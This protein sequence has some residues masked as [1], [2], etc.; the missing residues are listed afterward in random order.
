M[1]STGATYTCTLALMIQPR[2]SKSESRV[3]GVASKVRGQDSSRAEMVQMDIPT[4]QLEIA[5]PVLG[6]SECS[7]PFLCIKCE[8]SRVI[9][10]TYP[11]S[12]NIFL[13]GKELENKELFIT[14]ASY[15]LQKSYIHKLTVQRNKPCL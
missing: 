10:L 3:L 13:E 7:F 6:E 9:I 12:C 15:I 11:H 8:P 1:R 14:M 4:F 2:T 5:Y